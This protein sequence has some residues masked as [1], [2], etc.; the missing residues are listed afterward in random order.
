MTKDRLVEKTRKLLEKWGVK[1]EE[2]DKFIADLEAEDE[3]VVEETEIEE[4]ETETEETTDAPIEEEVVED[5]VEEEA[6]VEEDETTET[7][8]TIE[9]EVVE[10]ETTPEVEE[11]AKEEV[12]EHEEGDK[13]KWENAEAKFIALGGEIAELKKIVEGLRDRVE[14]GAFGTTGKLPPQEDDEWEG[15]HTK[16]YFKNKRF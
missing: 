4:A 3:E 12:V 11:E 2:A 7:E 15:E 1:G 5:K 8:E 16:A 13:D 9:E 6:P 14:G 10:E